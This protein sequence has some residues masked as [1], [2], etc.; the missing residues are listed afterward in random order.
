[1]ADKRT[2]RRK[3]WTRRRFLQTAG[4][5]TAAM[6]ADSA[7]AAYGVGTPAHA[8][9]LTT[10]PKPRA[11]ARIRLLQ[12]NSFV[13]VADNELK[14]QA[15]EWGDANGVTVAAGDGPDIIQMQYGWPHLYTASTLTVTNEVNYLI[16]RLGKVHPVNEAYCKVRGEWRAIPYTQVPNA[17]SYRTDYFDK[18]GVRSFPKTWDELLAAGKKVADATGKPIAQ[19]VG[20]AYGDSLTMWNPVL[21]GFGGQEVDKDGRTVTISSSETETALRWAIRAA[22]AGIKWFPEWLDPD[23]NQAYHADRISA[24]LNGASIYIREVIEFKH[25]DRV[26]DNAPMPSGPKGNFTLNLVMNHAVMSW[27][28]ERDTAK[29]FLLHIMDKAVYSKWLGAARGYNAGPFEAFN[30][31]PVW[32]SDPKIKAYRDVVVDARGQPI[33]QWAGWPAAPS[34]WTSQSQTQFVVADMFAKAVATG[35]TSAAIKDAEAKLKAIY[36]RY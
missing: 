32:K 15:K 25:F 36:G 33:G 17:W 1:M 31:D 9:P 16:G 20:H 7:L 19:T 24:T 29:A 34:K 27:S 28:R 6:A 21:W 5:A 35:D 13:R 26:T 23:N 3:G 10:L 12:W 11:G 22:Q 14:R 4:A 2:Q 30:N 8:A 18:A